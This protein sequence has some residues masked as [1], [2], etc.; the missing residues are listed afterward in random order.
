MPKPLIV[1]VDPGGRDTGVI[2]RQ[3]DQLHAAAIVTRDGDLADYLAEVLDTIAGYAR[4]HPA[5]ADVAA[6]SCI[7]VEDVTAPTGHARGREGHIIDPAGIIET[8]KVFGAILATMTGVVVVDA[9]GNGSQPLALYPELLV[10]P[11][12]RVGTGKRRHLRS[13]WDVAGRAELTMRA[14][15]R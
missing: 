11:L 7:A 6:V 4:L 15:R 9:G 5:G 10:G 8:A 2:L 13:A 14:A 12:E 1:G 3:G